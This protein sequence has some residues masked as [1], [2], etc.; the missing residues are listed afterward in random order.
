MDRHR[1]IPDYRAIAAIRYQTRRVCREPAEEALQD[2]NGR[3]FGCQRA[4]R[5]RPVVVKARE[6]FGLT[7]LSGQLLTDI[8]DNEWRHD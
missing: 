1:L 8:L 6:E 2:E 3:W 5:I 4:V 7:A